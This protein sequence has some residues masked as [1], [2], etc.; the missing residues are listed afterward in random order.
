M[1]KTKETGT[2]RRQII[3]PKIVGWETGKHIIGAVLGPLVDQGTDSTGKH[4]GFLMNFAHTETGEVEL[5]GCP[6][7]L[8]N[9]LERMTAAEKADIEIRCL[10]KIKTRSRQDAWDFEVFTG[11]AE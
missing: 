10:G 5:I 9:Y 4:L 1:A 7:I 8:K 3:R 2:T 11:A 6:T